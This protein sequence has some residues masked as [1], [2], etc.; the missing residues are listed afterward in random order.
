MYTVVGHVEG[1]ET[2]VGIAEHGL[3][4]VVPVDSAP[5]TTGLP[6]T[7]QES[8]NI[9]RIVGVLQRDPPVLSHCHLASDRSPRLGTGPTPLGFEVIGRESAE[10]G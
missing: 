9:E 10:L 5:A 8:A 2:G 6:H 1:G 3:N 7:V 4:G